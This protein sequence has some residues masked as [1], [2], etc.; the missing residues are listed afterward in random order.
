MLEAYG[1][2]GWE[3]N[4][5][6]RRPAIRRYIGSLA[7]NSVKILPRIL[8]TLIFFAAF[9]G[10]VFHTRLYPSIIEPDSTAGA[11][12]TQLNNEW[13]RPKPNRNQVLAVGHSRMALLPRIA[14]E[15]QPSTGYRFASVG[16]GGTTPRCWYY[17]L[18][19]LDPRAN[20]YAAII[21]PTDDFNE[22]D[23]YENPNER[24]LDTR[25]LIA[26]LKL[27]DLAE[28]P[29][30]FDTFKLKWVTAGAMLFKGYVY[31]R[32]FLDFIS[33]SKARLAKVELYKG[34]SAGW[35]YDYVGPNH[36]VAGLQIDWQHNVATYPANFTPEQR[37]LM[38]DVLFQPRPPDAGLYTRYLR[39]WYG[40]I[41]DHYRGSST[42]LIFLRVP[43]APMPPPDHPPKLD[44]AIR[45]IAT[46]PEVVVLD[47][48]LFDQLEHTDLFADPM[49]LNAEGMNRFSRILAT[50]VR[51]VLGP[52]KS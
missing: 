47:E 30:S 49:H 41:L 22:P 4:R 52:P 50:E 15:M 13:K 24:E 27:R 40:R 3:V 9:E 1:F 39:R 8:A 20:R 45:Q 11:M 29:E 10:V 18:R 26:R 35:F 7:A 46:E 37:K 31:K 36:S 21:I 51:R 28:F 17:E 43:R 38:E 14:N 48:H 42:K 19:E 5:V 12:E 34:F 25:Y 2:R 32:D 16:I 44:S 33:H 23:S 6:S